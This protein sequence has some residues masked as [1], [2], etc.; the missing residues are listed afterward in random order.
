MVYEDQI[1]GVYTTKIPKLGLF[2]SFFKTVPG[3]LIFIFL[4]FAILITREAMHAF[5]LYKEIK[6]E[7]KKSDA[8][9]EISLDDKEELERIRAEL[10]ELRAELGKDTDECRTE[11]S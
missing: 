2:I 9:A 4:P 6:E 7:E 1:I 3:Y 11:G 10:A 5:S 8:I